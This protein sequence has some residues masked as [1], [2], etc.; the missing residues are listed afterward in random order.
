M[1]VPD[2]AELAR[3]VAAAEERLAAALVRRVGRARERVG[4]LH[5]ALGDPQRRVRDLALRL[6]DLAARA[7]Q[8][9]VRRVAWDRRELGALQERLARSGPGARVRGAEERLAGA[10]ER[11]RFAL[12]VRVRHARA[13]LEQATARLDA[14]SPLACLARGYALVR[15]GDDA[16]PVVRDAGTLA[17]DDRIVV[18]FAAGRARARVEDTEG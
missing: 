13:G 1:V 9:L 10:A 12:A 5:R 14:L 15:K 3:A 17:R 16:G 11:L 2:R 8:A 7:R 6:D 4:S 18:R